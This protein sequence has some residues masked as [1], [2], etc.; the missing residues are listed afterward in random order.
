MDSPQQ[1]RAM[2][3]FP[4]AHP[5]S[6]A[7]QRRTDKSKSTGFSD[8]PRYIKC[9]VFCTFPFYGACRLGLKIV[10][11]TVEK[12]WELGVK[13]LETCEILYK[14][15][16]NV[17]NK[18]APKVWNG[19][20]KPYIV[21]PINNWI[22]TPIVRVVQYVFDCF[23]AVCVAVYNTLC[24]VFISIVDAWSSV[25]SAMFGNAPRSNTD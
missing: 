6:P 10:E 2:N 25:W 19:F 13:V 17:Y 21:S 15:C 12:T 22:I 16:R 5:P 18:I 1:N 24:S 20:V 8:Q 4:A 9:L 7:E 23:M 11:K 14:V 3:R